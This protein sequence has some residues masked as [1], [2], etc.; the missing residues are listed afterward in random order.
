MR[1]G[2]GWGGGETA[3]RTSWGWGLDPQGC[4]TSSAAL[5]QPLSRSAGERRQGAGRGWWSR[6][7]GRF[8]FSA[9]HWARSQRGRLGS[10]WWRLQHLLPSPPQ[11]GA[12][13]HTLG[14]PAPCSP[15][16]EGERWFWSGSPP[17]TCQVPQLRV[18]WWGAGLAGPVLLLSAL[19]RHVIPAVTASHRPWPSALR[20]GLGLISLWS[21]GA[22]HTVGS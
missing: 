5:H 16:P 4:C 19:V 9:P 21:S 8:G 15:G 11:L 18:R 17:V 13:R 12:V 10:P 6:A 2:Q 20:P 3:L 14:V 7:E 22:W 1:R